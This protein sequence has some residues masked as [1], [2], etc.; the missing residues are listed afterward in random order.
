MQIDEGTLYFADD[1]VYA[2]SA[3]SG[4]ARWHE[5]LGFNQSMAFSD[6]AL[7]DGRLYVARVGGS[8]QGTLYSLDARSGAVVWQRGQLGQLGAPVAG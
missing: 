7:L 1:G 2:V 6:N 5:T 4:A 3:A 8:G